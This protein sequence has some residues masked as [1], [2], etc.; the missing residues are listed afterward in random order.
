MIGIFDSGSGG[1][2]VLRAIRER[3]PS[4]DIVYFGDIKNAPYGTK[5]QHEL[6]ALTFAA[7]KLLIKEG[8]TSV[9]SACNSASTTLAV[10]LL[11]AGDISPDRVIEM[12]GPTV[13]ALKHTDADILIAATPATI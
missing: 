11:D 10:S 3:M 7:F 4:A 1:L 12:V 6:S 2:T 9:V 5:S 8:S 13:R